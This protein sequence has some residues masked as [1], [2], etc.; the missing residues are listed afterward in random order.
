MTEDRT[1]LS[2]QTSFFTPRRDRDPFVATEIHGLV[3]VLRVH[4]GWVDVMYVRLGSRVEQGGVMTRSPEDFKVG[5]EVLI[6]LKPFIILEQ[7]AYV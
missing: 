6:M 4:W 5:L 2:S 1:Q 7:V 3:C